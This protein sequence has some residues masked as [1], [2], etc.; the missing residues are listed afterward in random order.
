MNSK[1]AIEKTCLEYPCCGCGPSAIP[2]SRIV[3]Q[4]IR[5]PEYR[6]ERI[7]SFG[8]W[9]QDNAHELERYYNALKPYSTEGFEPLTDFFEFAAIQ[10]EREDVKLLETVS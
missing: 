2:L 5:I 7:R 10:H 9:F 4:P 1:C 6:N 8:L 3:Q